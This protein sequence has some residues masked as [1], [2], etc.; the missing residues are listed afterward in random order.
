MFKKTE[1]TEHW[2][3]TAEDIAQFIGTEFTENDSLFL[4]LHGTSMVELSI[5]RVPISTQWQVAVEG[6][7]A[8]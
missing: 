4:T 3:L 5:V 7:S 8:S 6:Y 2:T 1:I